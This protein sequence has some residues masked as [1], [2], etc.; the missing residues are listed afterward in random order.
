VDQLSLVDLLTADD[1]DGDNIQAETGA[2]AAAA[3]ST[4]RMRPHRPHANGTSS[5]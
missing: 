4:P 5:V 1:D 2:S 3:G